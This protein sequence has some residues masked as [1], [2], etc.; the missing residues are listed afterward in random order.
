MILRQNDALRTAQYFLTDFAKDI[1][2][3]IDL[4]ENTFRV[5]EISGRPRQR[6]SKNYSQNAK[7]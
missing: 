7:K 4:S 2:E 5:R 6:N 3:W 1:P